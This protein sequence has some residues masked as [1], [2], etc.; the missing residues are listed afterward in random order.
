MMSRIELIQE[1]YDQLGME[2][3]RLRALPFD[4]DFWII[5]LDGSVEHSSAFE[6]ELLCKMCD[7]GNAYGTKELAL[8]A[9]ELRLIIVEA[10]RLKGFKRTGD[11][12]ESYRI[13]WSKV[14]KDEIHASMVESF[15]AYLPVYFDTLEDAKAAVA[16]LG[17]DRIL[18]ILSAGN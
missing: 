5:E 9:V 11:D 12:A 18:K 10:Q 3:I 4:G 1:Q 17:Y 13:E 7:L 6:A 8:E 15:D 2:L 14:A 16:T